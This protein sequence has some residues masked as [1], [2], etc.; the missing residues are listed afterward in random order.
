MTSSPTTTGVICWGAGIGSNYVEEVVGVLKAYTTRVGEGPLPTTVDPDTLSQF[1]GAE[2]FREVGT[3]TGRARRIGWLDLVLARYAVEI[4]GV[5]QLALTKLDV[6]DRH[7]EIKICVGYH[8]H[9]EQID[10][11]PPLIEDFMEVEPIYETLPGWES[12]T[13]EVTNIRGL[14]SNARKFIDAIEEFTSVPIS[15]VSVGPAREE[16]IRIDEEWL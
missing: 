5:Q 15:I 11:P 14:P 2:D 9:G 13:R 1:E 12:S 10:K 3:T 6:L 16:T 8:L 4:N 7:E